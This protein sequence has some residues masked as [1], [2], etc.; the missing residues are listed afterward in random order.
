MN[1]AKAKLYGQ[2]IRLAKG[3]IKALEEYVQEEM[4]DECSDKANR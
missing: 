4:K 3:M 2:L 1:K